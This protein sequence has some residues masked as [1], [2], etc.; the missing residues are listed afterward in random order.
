MLK[1]SILTISLL[2]PLAAI[3]AVAHAGSTIS[4]KSYWP[5]EARRS[6]QSRIVATQPDL[7]SAF[8]YGGAR[9]SAQEEPSADRVPSSWRY[10]GGPK[11]R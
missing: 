2:L 4:D 7:S 9:S 5:N 11:G 6:T 3:S 8:A 1:K 10:Q